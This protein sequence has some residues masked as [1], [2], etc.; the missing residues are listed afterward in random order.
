[1]CLT[2]KENLLHPQGSRPEHT[3]ATEKSPGRIL[4]PVTWGW[5]QKSTLSG[6]M[7]H[8]PERAGDPRPSPGLGTQVNTALG[9]GRCLGPTP[10]AV[11]GTNEAPEM[12]VK[13]PNMKHVGSQEGRTGWE[14]GLLGHSPVNPPSLGTRRS[15][16]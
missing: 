1:M 6:P 10:G 7:S 16:C 9:T 12:P 5:Q 11:S 4:L 14:K 8:H 2:L 13:S 3:A 15:Q